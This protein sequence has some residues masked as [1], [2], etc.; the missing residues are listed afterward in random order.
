M[1]I[2]KRFIKKQALRIDKKYWHIA[3]FFFTF[4]NAALGFVAVI[5]ALHDYYTSAAVCLLLACFMDMC[6]GRVA[7]ALGV[8]SL[9]GGELDSLCDAV[10]FCFAPA[11]LLYSWM[12]YHIPLICSVVL[13]FYLFSGLY[14]LAKFNLMED[15]KSYF[16]GLP[17]PIAAG[18]IAQMIIFEQTFSLYLFNHAV[19]VFLMVLA[20]AVLMVSPFKIPSFK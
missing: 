14:R 17:T 2:T 13:V 19:F 20:I 9:L 16:I 15:N 8:E 12:F 3:P 7:R 5:Y 18:L 1:G 6:D 4:A 10:S 11:I